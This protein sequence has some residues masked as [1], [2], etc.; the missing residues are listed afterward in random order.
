MAHQEA[1]NIAIFAHYD[2]HNL[3][4]D[5][6]VIYLQN[7][8]KFCSKIIFVSDGDLSVLEQQK[9]L[10]ITSD[11][12]ATR[13]QEYDF[14]SYKQGFNLLKKKYPQEF[15]N[16]D[17]LVLAN[18]SCYCVGEFDFTFSQID[19]MPNIDCFG[20]TDSGE[21]C[22]HLQ[23]YFLVLK[24]TVFLTS[25][26]ENF[27]Q[28]IQK[29]NLKQNIIEAYEI[30]FSQLLAQNNKKIY[31]IY[32][33]NFIQNYVNQNKKLIKQKILKTIGLY[34][35]IFGL[36]RIYNTLFKISDCYS[37]H[38]AFQ[39]L[40]LSGC[41]LLKR[42]IILKNFMPKKILNTSSL[43]YFWQNIVGKETSYSTK[44]ISDHAN[45]ISK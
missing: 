19:R 21:I 10:H 22:H 23:S 40:I 34:Q 9:I 44:V 16:L 29:Q 24:K 26:F 8:K 12:I 3:I 36:K 25:F 30:G 18:D 28:N 4:D 27:L 7:L 32:G 6:V 1:K 5:Y 39:P 13:H 38:N 31:A 42:S 15:S 43:C 41:P 33:K 2:K 37:Y 11:I 14:G 35:K 20:I 17:Q 45:R